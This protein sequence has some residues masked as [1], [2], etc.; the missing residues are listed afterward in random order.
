MDE[1]EKAVGRVRLDRRV[2]L[3]VTPRT[4][5]VDALA[6]DLE[7]IARTVSQT[8]RELRA[9]IRDVNASV[10]MAHRLCDAAPADRE[11]DG[12]AAE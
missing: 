1:N 5:E 8:A 2:V 11:D 6:S 3:E 12:G 7:E 9:C 10:E 4:D